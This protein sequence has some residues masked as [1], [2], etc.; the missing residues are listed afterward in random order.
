MTSIK[1]PKIPVIFKLYA[2]AVCLP[3]CSSIIS[4]SAFNSNAKAITEDSP[5]SNLF[6]KDCPKLTLLTGFTIIQS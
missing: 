4:Q 2:V 6:F 1:I 5:S 3:N